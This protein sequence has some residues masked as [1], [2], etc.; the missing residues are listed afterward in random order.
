[1][2]DDR[3]ERYVFVMAGTMTHSVSECYCTRLEAA[4]FFN[5]LCGSGGV[6]AYYGPEGFVN[7]YHDPDLFGGHERVYSHFDSQGHPT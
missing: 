4:D 2:S 7:A 3:T 5:T 1:M 6:G